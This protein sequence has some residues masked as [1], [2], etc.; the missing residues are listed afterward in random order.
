MEPSPAQPPATSEILKTSVSKPLVNSSDNFFGAGLISEKLDPLLVTSAYGNS[1]IVGRSSTGKSEAVKFALKKIIASGLT[2][3]GVNRRQKIQIFSVN[4]RGDLLE[5]LGKKLT[6]FEAIPKVPAESVVIIE[7]VINLSKKEHDV[8]RE[9]LNYLSHHKRLRTFTITHHLWKT[10]ILT[11]IPFYNYLIFTNTATSIPLIRL[12]LSQFSLGEKEV[13]EIV[14][15][16]KSKGE[17]NF[18]YFVLDCRNLSFF[19]APNLASLVE[20]K[21]QLLEC[22]FSLSPQNNN[23][24]SNNNNSTA[25]VEAALPDAEER[26]KKDR[27]VSKFK[28]FVQHHKIKETGEVVFKMIVESIP[29]SLIREVDLCFQFRFKSGES[30]F[31]SLVDYVSFLLTKESGPATRELIFFHNYLKKFCKIPSIY[32]QNKSLSHSSLLFYLTACCRAVGRSENKEGKKKFERR[33]SNTNSCCTS[34][35]IGKKMKH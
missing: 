35:S 20:S 11:S 34:S 18:S 30:G 12:A 8:L 16:V 17:K 21:N 15:A 24:S 23:S 14:G 26:E 25:V 10:G 7:D 9:M 6:S 33:N 31:V 13:Q 27:L 29:L 32:V 2:Q 3:G 28:E 1:L 4:D 19:Y 5:G 22:L